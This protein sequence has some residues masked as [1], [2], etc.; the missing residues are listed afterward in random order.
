MSFSGLTTILPSTRFNFLRA[1]LPWQ[2]ISNNAHF[3]LGVDAKIILGSLM[4]NLSTSWII[5][6]PSPSIVTNICRFKE[7][8]TSV[9]RFSLF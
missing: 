3:R 7:E 2:K 6:R 9:G 8:I 4:G 1:Y 5:V